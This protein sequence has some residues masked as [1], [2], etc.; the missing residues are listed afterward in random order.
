MEPRLPTSEPSPPPPGREALDG[1][2]ALAEKVA[3]P[4]GTRIVCL[5]DSITAPAPYA[6]K[7]PE[8]LAMA[9]AAARPGTV[10]V[11]NAGIGGDDVRKAFKRVQADV[12]SRRPTLVFINLGVNDSKLVAPGYAHNFVPLEQ[13]KATYLDL[14]RKIQ[15]AAG[16]E[17]TVVGTLACVEEWTRA[18]AVGGPTPM[19]H[20]GVP[21][22]L[23]RYNAAAH[24]A[25]KA[26]G[27]DYVELWEPFHSHPDL[28]SLFPENDGV[29]AGPRGQELIALQVM[30]HLAGKHPRRPFS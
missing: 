9:F 13:F 10:E 28:K 7:Y 16:A 21:E 3:L 12:I 11:V 8:I 1:L 17:V 26:L 25:G 2:I 19:N 5:G 23:H 4:D 6:T 15:E 29:H 18:K 22:Q 20:F 30:R 14:I 24:E 27:C